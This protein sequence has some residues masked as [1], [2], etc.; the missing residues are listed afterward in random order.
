M[1]RLYTREVFGSWVGRLFEP[2][3]RRLLERKGIGEPTEV[4]LEEAFAE[5]W[6]ECSAK[7]MVQEPWMG[8]IRFKSLARYMADEFEPMVL[9]PMGYLRERFGGGKFKVNFY[10]G[11]HFVATQNFKPEGDPKWKEMPELQED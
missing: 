1:A 7:V 3:V 10:R 2:F 6:K 5:L 11:M 9:D 4:D 8:T